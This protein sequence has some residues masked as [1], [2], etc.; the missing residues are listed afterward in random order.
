MNLKNS[1]GI[2]KRKTKENLP[3]IVTAVAAIGSAAV[4]VYTNRKLVN[5]L[6]DLMYPGRTEFSLHL[7]GR[8]MDKLLSGIPKDAGDGIFIA[9]VDMIKDEALELVPKAISQI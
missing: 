9:T 1:F 4:V 8:E 2:V 7:S 6:V 3:T 5:N